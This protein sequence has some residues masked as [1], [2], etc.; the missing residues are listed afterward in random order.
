MALPSAGEPW[1]GSGA[2]SQARSMEGQRRAGQARVRHAGTGQGRGLLASASRDGDW[3]LGMLP[4]V[5]RPDAEL[6]RDSA[7]REAEAVPGGAGQED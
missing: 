2:A 1:E 7:R 4:A 3:R 6:A 5:S